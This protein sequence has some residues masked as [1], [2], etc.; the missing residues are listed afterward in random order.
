MIKSVFF[1]QSQSGF[2]KVRIFSNQQ[3]SLSRISFGLHIKLKN[4]IKIKKMKPVFLKDHEKS[5]F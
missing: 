2:D 5:A 3:R 4:Q 1:K